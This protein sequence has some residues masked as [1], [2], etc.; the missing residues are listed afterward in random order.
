MIEG[1]DEAD[2]HNADLFVSCIPVVILW[3]RR[4]RNS[5]G[6]GG[7]DH[8]WQS[9]DGEGEGDLKPLAGARPRPNFRSNGRS[10][11]KLPSIWPG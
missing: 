6:G 10:N 11:A 4:G 3:W 7:L 8:D 9:Q 5:E 2:I 1:L